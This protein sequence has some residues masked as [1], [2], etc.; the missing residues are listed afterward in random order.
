MGNVKTTVSKNHITKAVPKIM[1]SVFSPEEIANSANRLDIKN[2][3]IADATQ[4]H[5]PS[6][7]FKSVPDSSAIADALFLISLF[8]SINPPIISR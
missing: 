2:G 3:I 8:V 5:T 6:E 7:S 1:L 4:I